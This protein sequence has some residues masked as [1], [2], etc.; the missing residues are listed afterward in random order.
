MIHLFC[1][2]KINLGLAVTARLPNGYHSLESLFIPLTLGDEIHVTRS[3]KLSLDVVGA[4][5][6]VGPG[7][8]VYRAAQC[9]LEAIGSPHGV[10]ITLIKKV[11]IAAGLGG[12]SSDAAHT[13]LALKELYP[14]EVDLF[15]LAL[16]LGADVPFFLRRKPAFVTGIGDQQKTVSLPASF[17]PLVAINVGIPISTVDAYTWFDADAEPF[18]PLPIDTLLDAIGLGLELPYFNALQAPVLRRFPEL[19]TVL[20]ALFQVG[21]HSPLMSGSGSTCFAVAR[22]E[23][24]AAGAERQLRRRYPNAW[25]AQTSVCLEGLGPIVPTFNGTDPDASNVKQT[26]R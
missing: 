6:P 20:E 22:D 18:A 8:L 15:E 17:G 26:G 7:N 25:I 19:Q 21:L 23:D 12:G 1:P 16:R 5:L 10:D 9:Y 11:P 4:S 14:S 3:Q 24:S 2:A 13:L